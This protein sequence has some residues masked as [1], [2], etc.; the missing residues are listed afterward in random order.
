[1]PRVTEPDARIDAVRGCIALERGPLVYAVETVDLRAGVDVEGLAIDRSQPV[2]DRPRPEVS[3][4]AVG[5]TAHVVHRRPP[6]AAGWPY[7]P[8]TP[9]VAN[10]AAEPAEEPTLPDAVPYFAWAN[11]GPGGM[12]VW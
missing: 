5:L 9:L 8:A 4:A 6:A 3:E 7:R 12:R 1:T 10:D 11:R 2:V